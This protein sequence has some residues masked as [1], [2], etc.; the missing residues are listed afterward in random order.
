MAK[1]TFCRI[2]AGELPAEVVYEDETIIAFLDN[3]PLERGHT[4]VVPKH[5]ARNLFDID[6]ELA[7]Q[8]TRTVARIAQ[9]L[10]VSVG[11]NGLNVNQNNEPAAGQVIF[12]YHVHLIPRREGQ[13]GRGRLSLSQ[14][15]MAFIGQAIRDQLYESYPTHLNFPS[16]EADNVTCPKGC[17]A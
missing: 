12:H 7:A 6:P 8:V 16:C 4:L 13:I 10:M 15:E 3:A 2:I 9:P 11:A 17:R 14:E 5:H 1:C